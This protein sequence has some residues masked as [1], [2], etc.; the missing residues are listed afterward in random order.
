MLGWLR[1]DGGEYGASQR[2][3]LLSI[4]VA[5]HANDDGRSANSIGMLSYV[6]AFAGHGSVAIEIADAAARHCH[7]EPALQARILGRVATAHAASGNLAGFQSA[8]DRARELLDTPYSGDTP[9]YLYYLEPDQLI[10]EAG[11]GLVTLATQ[12]PVY[13]NRLLKDAIAQ[14]TPISTASSRPEYPRAALLHSCFLIDAHIGR[15]DLEG[16]VAATR[17]AMPR[18]EQVQSARCLAHLRRIERTFAKRSRATVVADF[19]PELRE[20]LA[21]R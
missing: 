18:L 6:S 9:P 13:R 2:Y 21:S 1:F 14:L 5:R 15:G 3:L 4:R 11:Q 16:A 19:L 17:E 20:A 7:N 10:A 12:A 8:S